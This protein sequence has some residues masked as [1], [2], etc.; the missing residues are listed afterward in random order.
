MSSMYPPVTKAALFRRLQA[1]DRPDLAAKVEDLRGRVDSYLRGVN[2]TFQHF[3][4]HAVDHSDQIVRE[5]S[6]L[7]FVDPD[8]QGS[9]SVNLSAVET[10]LLLLAAYLHDAGMVVTDDEKF[11]VLASPSWRE[12]AEANT[13]V[14]AD[15]AELQRGLEAATDPFTEPQALFVNSLEQR[16]LLADYFRR[17]HA[18]R[19]K[20]AL[21]GALRVGDDFLGGDPAALATLTAICVGHGL[22]RGELASDTIYPTRRDIFGEGVNIRL[23]AILLRLGDLLDMRF[24]R[25]CPLIHSIASPLPPSSDAHWS[26]Y[27]RI[28]N[29][30]TSPAR[31]EIRGECETADEHRILR[32][33]CSWIVEEIRDAPK[34][35]AGSQRHQGW[36]PPKATIGDSLDTIQIMRAAGARYRAEDWKF[37][38][39][40]NEI[41]VRLVRDVHR[42]RFGFLRELLQNSLDTTRARAYQESGAPETYPNLLKADILSRF[43]IAVRLTVDG[44]RVSSIEIVDQG[45]G[46]TQDVVRNY[47]LQIGRSWY[48]SSEFSQQFHFSPTSRFGI[49]FLSVFAVSDDVQVTTRW[50]HDRAENALAMK[51]PG[52]KS[53]LLFE[54]SV[55]ETPGTSV[56]VAL[57]ERVELVD[58]VKYLES[59]CVA[60]EFPIVV[61]T[62]ADGEEVVLKTLPLGSDRQAVELRVGESLV[63]STHRVHSTTP[64]IFGYIEFATVAKSGESPDWSL[65]K[66]AIEKVATRTNPLVELP[67]LASAWTAINGLASEHSDPSYMLSDH[68]VRWELDVRAA[69]AF[70]GAGLDRAGSGLG[71]FPSAD[72]ANSLED[73]LEERA[74][75]N[76]YKGRLVRR[77][78]QFAPAWADKVNYIPRV[79]G[80]AMS[81]VELRRCE[82]F[83]A[84]FRPNAL[85]AWPGPV[86]EGEYPALENFNT[87]ES[88]ATPLLSPGGLPSM[89]WQARDILLKSFRVERIFEV[90]QNLF[91]AEFLAADPRPSRDDY[92]WAEFEPDSTAV[93][94]S[95]SS[96][97][98]ILNL[99]HPFLRAVLEIPD[100]YAVA[101]QRL[102]DRVAKPH[103]LS[104]ESLGTVIEG[105]GVA[106]N[107]PTLIEFA[108]HIARKGYHSYDFSRG[109]NLARDP[110]S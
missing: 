1:M 70:D 12:F 19:S 85:Y 68:S 86:S 71:H 34:L 58:L 103:T 84:V 62:V 14:A 91:I 20:V 18:D 76:A 41:V 107:I 25:A 10:Y 9:I 48:R 95:F 37:T 8:D 39:D 101:R 5:M 53:Y 16:L 102:I 47:F 93:V 88:G 11:A 2:N 30:V 50:H 24:D 77:F 89:S 83:F 92:E 33:W 60:N 79:N 100:E 90:S 38:F 66:T 17:H 108:A 28:T 94:V 78:S 74:R 97:K 57:N 87:K 23:L 29:R 106:L 49:G 35:L 7:L 40:E 3:T 51:L 56:R 63:Y 96:D 43:P 52:P 15:V 42:H 46:M 72:L 21:S 104:D 22:N 55:R 44:P 73:H 4:S 81:H 31:I 99:N 32:D 27:H 110:S 109:I 26:Q 61:S 65:G 82:K 64:G 69:P 98:R 45:L 36:H 75:S 6:N 80:K 59:C 67:P 13:V 105:V 54:D